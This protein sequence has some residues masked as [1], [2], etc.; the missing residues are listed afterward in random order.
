LIFLKEAVFRLIKARSRLPEAQKRTALPIGIVADEYQ[1]VTGGTS[2]LNSIDTCRSLG[3]FMIVGFQ[4]INSL[5]SV[6][7]NPATVKAMLAN[8]VQKIIFATS[9]TDTIEWVQKLFGNAEVYREN[10]QRGNSSST[11]RE[12]S[13]TKSENVTGQ[14]VSLPVVT[15]QT[16][17]DLKQTGKT[18]Q[19]LAM[20]RIG[21]TTYSDVIECPKV[22]AS[23][24]LT[25]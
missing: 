1:K 4:S 24:I 18:T 11:G 12:N 14:L 6:I 23:D 9:D 25:A 22:Y 15:A 21:G 19:G 20:F 10:A 5:H 13:Y 3:G 7:R 17:H 8:L 2:D 16:F